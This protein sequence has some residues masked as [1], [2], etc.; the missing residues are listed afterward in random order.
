MT[1]STFAAALG[2]RLSRIERAAMNIEQGGRETDLHEL[3]MALTDV[4]CLIE[5]DPGIEAATEDLYETALA[6]VRDATTGPPSRRLRLLRE[7]R[8]RYR[9]RLAGARPSEELQ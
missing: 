6:V 8:I 3:R 4:L 5:R 9:E 7:V 2:D 1:L